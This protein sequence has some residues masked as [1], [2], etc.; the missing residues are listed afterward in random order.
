MVSPNL[1][2]CEESS[3]ALWSFCHLERYSVLLLVPEGALVFCCG[4]KDRKNCRRSC[5]PASK[6]SILLVWNC[7]LEN[8][9]VCEKLHIAKEVVAWKSGFVIVET[10]PVNVLSVWKIWIYLRWIYGESS[11]KPSE[12]SY[13]VVI[14]A[15]KRCE[16]L[17]SRKELRIALRAVP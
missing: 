17:S 13:V 11:Q 15:R 10:Y 2:W 1:R 14:Q 16:G 4:T 12:G 3:G 6:K 8:F 7:L 9:V 5:S